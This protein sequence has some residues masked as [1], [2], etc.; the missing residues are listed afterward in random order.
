M[1]G[2]LLLV[3]GI[4]VAKMQVSVDEGKIKVV[5]PPAREALEQRADSLMKAGDYSGALEVYG[6]LYDEFG[7]LGYLQSQG[8]CYRK[9]GKYEEAFR[10]Y[11][12]VLSLSEGRWEFSIPALFGIGRTAL[13]CGDYGRGIEVLEGH[14]GDL[15][16]S[17]LVL[18]GDLYFREGERGKAGQAYMQAFVR[19]LGVLEGGRVIPGCY[20]VVP[21][22]RDK[23]EEEAYI[24]AGELLS[25]LEE[26]CSEK[27]EALLVLGEMAW[28]DRDWEGALK[29]FGRAWEVLGDPMAGLQV[30]KALV[31]LGRQDEALDVLGGLRLGT[32][33]GMLELS[34]AFWLAGD[35]EGARGVL[36]EIVERY[37]GSPDAGEAK[38]R[39]EIMERLEA[40]R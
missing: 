15:V 32:P 28:E 39:L 12:E 5:I 18:L 6:E 20:G 9:M 3:L 26:M 11:G 38:L 37:P 23:L 33:G 8:D 35:F 34:G 40:V 19:R 2:V 25:G 24:K 21:Q 16:S 4:G 14:R 36:E 13:E 10:V 22:E 7:E 27:P 29:W 1:I 31:M 30:A 17:L